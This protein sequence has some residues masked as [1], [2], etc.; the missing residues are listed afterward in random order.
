VI[1]RSVKSGLPTNEALRIVAQGMPGAG[2]PEFSRWWK[3]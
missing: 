2:G 3:A 1:V